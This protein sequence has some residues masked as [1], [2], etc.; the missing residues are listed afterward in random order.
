[1]L[2]HWRLKLKETS[3]LRLGWICDVQRNDKSSYER[4]NGSYKKGACKESTR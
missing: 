3:K 4:N 1:M 2:L